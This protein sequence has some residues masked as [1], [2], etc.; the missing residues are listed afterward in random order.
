MH[1][2]LW[3]LK[4]SVTDQSQPQALTGTH[5]TVARVTK[6]RGFVFLSVHFLTLSY[7]PCSA[8]GCDGQICFVP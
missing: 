5:G 7:Q 3:M 8:G 6:T 2:L 1:Y 4:N